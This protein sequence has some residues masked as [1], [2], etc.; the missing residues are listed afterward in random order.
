MIVDD[1]PFVL[2][3]HTEMLR[4]M[5]HTASAFACPK[6]ALEY[7]QTHGSDVDLL[8][9]DFRMPD[10]NGIELIRR[11]RQ[12][13]FASPAMILTAYVQDVDVGEAVACGAKVVSK[14]IPMGLLAGYI[15]D[16]QAG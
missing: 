12:S 4:M 16:F 6:H 10:I 15:G 5:G 1:D 9:T 11:L 3:V 8:I 2:R 14:P 7:L 13:G